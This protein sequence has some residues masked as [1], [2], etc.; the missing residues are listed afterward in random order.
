[1]KTMAYICLATTLLVISSVLSGVM[2]I[3]SVASNCRSGNDA[4]RALTI[5]MRE[6]IRISYEVGDPSASIYDERFTRLIDT[7][8]HE[9]RC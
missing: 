7:L 8:L 3:R 4:K 9:E 5:V 1:M 6:S 2:I